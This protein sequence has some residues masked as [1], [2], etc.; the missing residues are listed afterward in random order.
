MPKLDLSKWR[1]ISN[2]RMARDAE[3]D[4]AIIVPIEGYTSVPLECP[5]CNFLL[6]DQDD[7]MSYRKYSCCSDC[8]LQW[9]Q[10]NLRKWNRGWRPE[11]EEIKK[12]KLKK[13]NLP[14]YMVNLS[15]ST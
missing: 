12:L 10:P 6:R 14:S 13:A 4:F 9:A 1:A 15:N 7:C 2:N 3:G 5:L 8:S 11:E